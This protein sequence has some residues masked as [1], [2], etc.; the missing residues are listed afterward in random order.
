MFKLAT[1]VI[2]GQHIIQYTERRNVAL[3]LEVKL[4]L[5]IMLTVMEMMCGYSNQKYNNLSGKH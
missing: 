1:Y 3:L 4:Q 5:C 2:Y